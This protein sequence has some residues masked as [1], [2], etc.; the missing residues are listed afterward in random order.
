MFSSITAMYCTKYRGQK[1]CDKPHTTQS[2]ATGDTYTVPEAAKKRHL[3]L[4]QTSGTERDQK[5]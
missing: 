4:M 5:L 3:W 2:S 1:G